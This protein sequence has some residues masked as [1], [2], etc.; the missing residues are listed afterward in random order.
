ML[1][2]ALLKYA[3]TLN[4]EGYSKNDDDQQRLNDALKGCIT[5]F[6]IAVLIDLIFVFYALWCL[7]NS[8][9]PW[10]LTTLLIV[11]MLYPGLGFMVSIGIIVYYHAVV[12]KQATNKVT[13]NQEGAF[14]FF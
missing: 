2:S 9:L 11:C 1:S 5:L 12:L 13:P 10:Y 7:F 6:I 4:T 8:H 3:C 14:L